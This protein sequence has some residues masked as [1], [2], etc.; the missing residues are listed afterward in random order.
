M[1][2][3]LS[4]NV[5]TIVLAGGDG[6]RLSRLIRTLH[7]EPLPKQFALIHAGQ[8]LLQSTV[9]RATRWSA[10]ERIVVIVAAEREAL[11]RAQL[12]RYPELTI[13]AQ[14]H[15]AGTGPGVALPVA[16]I[17]A[18]DP[19][20]QVVIL[21]SDHY[22]RHEAPFESSV[23]EA[24][25][26]TSNEPRRQLALIGAVPDQAETQYGWIV[27]DQGAAR[28]AAFREKPPSAE[29]LRL[30]RRGALWNTFVMVG[31][32]DDFW[33][34]IRH[35]LPEQA[36]LLKLYREAVGTRDEQNVLGSLYSDMPPADFSSDV[37]RHAR[38]LRVV[39]L[40]EC[41]WSDWGT[42]ERVLESLCHHRDVASLSQRMSGS[43]VDCP[44]A[45]DTQASSQAGRQR[46]T[47]RQVTSSNK[48]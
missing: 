37:L 2:A 10:R 14:P 11:A 28:V 1:D 23:R 8:S 18:R 35:H 15:D 36:A 22:V 9:A 42:P 21:P 25:V 40:C 44:R 3:T 43:D 26:E 47:S 32:V 33:S 38:D 30:Y 34:L 16:H 4:P 41:G 6:T 20:A 7:G 48:R 45:D 19:E 39:P 31:F 12:S 5:W 46:R 17:L 29:A 27:L 13:I 24:L